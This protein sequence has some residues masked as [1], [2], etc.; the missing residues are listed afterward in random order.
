MASRAEVWSK[1]LGLLRSDSRRAMA[2]V[3]ETRSGSMRAR[4]WVLCSLLVL[5]SGG[6]SAGTVCPYTIG[7]LV[8]GGTAEGVDALDANVSPNGVA[9]YGGA[10]YVNTQGRLR[11]IASDGTIQTIAGVGLITGPELDGGPALGADIG[12]AEELVVSSTGSLYFPDGGRY[13][14]RRVDP[15]GTIHT[16]AGTWNVRG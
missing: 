2:T 11:R 5:T 12:A 4:V 7:T 15:D 8:G 9:L 16:V 14:V 6:A 3:R 10:I 1:S 13:V